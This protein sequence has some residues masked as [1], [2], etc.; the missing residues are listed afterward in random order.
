MEGVIFKCRLS[1]PEELPAG[2]LFDVKWYSEKA[3]ET[4]K[5]IVTYPGTQSRSGKNGIVRL[6]ET[7]YYGVTDVALRRSSPIGGKVGSECC[8]RNKF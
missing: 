5:E 7:D 6:Y 4:R 1:K 2:V 3:G 8:S